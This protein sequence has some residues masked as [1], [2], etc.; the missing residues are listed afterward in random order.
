MQYFSRM[1]NNE[2]YKNPITSYGII[3]FYIDSSQKLWYLLA[4]RRDTIEYSDFIRGRYAVPDLELYFKLMTEDERNRLRNYSFE[5]LWDDLWI[6]HH[7]KFYR[8]IK[9]KARNR[10]DAQKSHMA[11]L[12]NTT[13]SIISEPSWGFP[14]GKRNYK[15]NEI[16]C[17]IREF[18][19]ESKLSIDYINLLSLPPSVEVFKGS[20][21]K[22]YSTVYYIAQVNQMIP[23]KKIAT[24]GIRKETISEEISNL[25]WCTIEQALPLLR[26]WRQKLLMD[27]ELKIRTH[28]T[29]ISAL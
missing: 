6:N 15:E 8:D 23:I 5:E 20:N 21:G 11:K 22:M 28:F 14:K 13:T 18:K 7:N 9:P 27:T 1:A 25:R 4:Q 10:F 17:A 12:L 19:E 26:P 29:E 3:L 2:P 24:T 16:E